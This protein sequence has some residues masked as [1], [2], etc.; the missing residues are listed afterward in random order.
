MRE[1]AGSDLR[2]PTCPSRLQP[3]KSRPEAPDDTDPARPCDAQAGDMVI[4][5]P[6]AWHTFVNTGPGTLRQTAIHQNPRA[7]SDFEDGTCRG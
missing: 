4:V 6:D 1:F 5:P 7:V 2:E 3:E